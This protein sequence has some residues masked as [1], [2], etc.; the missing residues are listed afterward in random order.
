[1]F[2]LNVHIKP[3]KVFFSLFETFRFDQITVAQEKNVGAAPAGIGP[4]DTWADSVRYRMFSGVPGLYPLSGNRL[5]KVMSTRN[6]FRRCQMSPPIG[7]MGPD[8]P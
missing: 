4:I 7:G 3:Q 5:P 8:C 6:V 2:S 1:M